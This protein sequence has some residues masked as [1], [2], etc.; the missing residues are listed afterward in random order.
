MWS[1]FEPK[2]PKTVP[3][4]ATVE[5][6]PQAPPQ[7]PSN[8]DDCKSLGA[9]E[10]RHALAEAAKEQR[11]ALAEAECLCPVS[12]VD[13]ESC[14][15]LHQSFISAT[16]Y[17]NIAVAGAKRRDPSEAVATVDSPALP[18][19][20]N[21]QQL[22]QQLFSLQPELLPDMLT[23]VRTGNA[24]RAVM[25]VPPGSMTGRGG[26]AAAG[27]G[28]QRATTENAVE[29]AGAE[30]HSQLPMRANGRS[31]RE[32]ERG[33]S[34]LAPC[35]SINHCV[36]SAPRTR[37]HLVSE[38]NGSGARLVV[39][40]GAGGAGI[41]A[42]NIGEVNICESQVSQGNRPWEGWQASGDELGGSFGGGG[43]GGMLTRRASVD[44]DTLSNMRLLTLLKFTMSADLLATGTPLRSPCSA[45][46]PTDS[47]RGTPINS[48]ARRRSG[49]VP[50]GT[51]NSPPGSVRHP[52]A[53]AA[54]LAGATRL[55]SLQTSIRDG[56]S[57]PYTG[58]SPWSSMPLEDAAPFSGQAAVVAHVFPPF[59]VQW[60]SLPLLVSSASSMG[61]HRAAA[62]SSSGEVHSGNLVKLFAATVAE[63]ASF[64][65]GGGGG[66]LV[67]KSGGL[68][69]VSVDHDGS[70]S[71]SADDEAFVEEEEEAEQLACFHEVTAKPVT[72]PAT[73]RPAVLITQIDVTYQRHMELGLEA[74]ARSQLNVLSQGF[75]RHIVEF[76]TSVQ[77][78]DLTA[79]MGDLARSHK[80][81]TILFM[82]IAGF[83]TMSRD[84]PASA[85]LTLVNTLFTR[86]DA[87]C[88]VYGVHKVDTAGDSYIVSSGVVAFDN[89]GFVQ[90][91]DEGMEDPI[92]CAH[93]IMAYAAAM[94]DAASEVAQPHNG[95]P[96][97]IRIGVHAGD[98]VSG[99]I[100]TKLP[101]FTLLGDTMNTASRM[102]STGKLNCIQVSAA[103]KAL[104]DAGQPPLPRL[105]FD[106]TSGVFVKGKGQMRTYIW[107]PPSEQEKEEDPARLQHAVAALVPVKG[108]GQ[109]QAYTT[110]P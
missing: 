9:K 108:K 49:C 86:F 17:S 47:L 109:M 69:P 8:E 51:R 89:E 66:S 76:F 20:H 34:V 61:A 72:D 85:V 45:N 60:P 70:G 6:P 24:W 41:D 84:V 30:A 32:L 103:A 42:D 3:G 101:K 99:L 96:V 97:S 25:E 98:C 91:L 12:L 27:E 15:V 39:V 36:D 16:Y 77:A 105:T 65:G 2:S 56:G 11:H 31:S 78:T 44:S 48:P 79:H 87:M 52:H 46:A 13:L 26:T 95:A 73:G 64:A 83:T 18:N 110:H 107:V 62:H 21:G 93:R 10:Q 38:A 92:E 75:P 50:V 29:R 1:C 106:A 102:E 58:L 53:S 23:I 81:V 7:E 74:L 33:S 40:G 55:G 100:G 54:N 63:H 19:G 43:S 28:Q 94:L 67:M 35:S 80:Q 22:L 5:A 37:V 104:L 57:S 59:L 71:G 90:V 14:E 82:D 4:P 88:N 68:V